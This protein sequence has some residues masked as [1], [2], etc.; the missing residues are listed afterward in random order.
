MTVVGSD[1]ELLPV[2]TSPD[3]DTDAVL[4]TA[5]AAA[6]ATPTVSVIWLEALEVSALER[7]QVT[8]WPAA[9]QDQP[10]PVP[11]T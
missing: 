9:E 6:E 10:V 1:A 3:V 4:V 7:V 11:E 2:A 8:V 5:G